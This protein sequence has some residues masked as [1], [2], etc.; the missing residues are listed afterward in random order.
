LNTECPSHKW[1]DFCAELRTRCGRKRKSWSQALKPM[2][3]SAA[4]RRPLSRGSSSCSCPH[5]P[6]VS[7]RINR[8]LSGWNLPP[9]MIRAFGA[10]CQR[11]PT[12]QGST[13][14]SRSRAVGDDATLIDPVNLRKLNFWG[15]SS[16]SVPETPLTM[17]GGRPCP[18]KKS[19]SLWLLKIQKSKH[20]G[21]WQ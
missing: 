17:A 9:L 13:R 15:D 19:P 18:T 3:P 10:H 12:G 20:L 5:P 8:Q 21:I 4:R 11:L 6:L 14:C 7:Y 16:V 2:A 1:R